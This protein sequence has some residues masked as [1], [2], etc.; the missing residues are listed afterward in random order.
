MAG[1]L[2]DTPQ[3]VVPE[4]KNLW[5]DRLRSHCA[6]DMDGGRGSGL[7]RWCCVPCHDHEGRNNRIL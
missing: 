7:E 5:L 2:L 6:V 4:R 1:S 3:Q